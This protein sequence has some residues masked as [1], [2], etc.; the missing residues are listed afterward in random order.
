MSLDLPFLDF[1]T[2]TGLAR[3]FSCLSIENSHPHEARLKKTSKKLRPH[4]GE[5]SKAEVKETEP[6]REASSFLVLL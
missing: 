3:F 4:E 2:P 5:A 6:K 1:V